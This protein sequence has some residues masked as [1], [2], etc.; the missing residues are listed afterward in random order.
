MEELHALEEALAEKR[1]DIR[2]GKRRLKTV[3]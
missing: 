1:N 3:K 2:G